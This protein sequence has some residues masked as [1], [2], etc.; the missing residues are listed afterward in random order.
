MYAIRSYY[1]VKDNICVIIPAILKKIVSEYKDIVLVVVE[2]SFD[3]IKE[4]IKDNEENK[5]IKNIRN[6]FV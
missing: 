2:S 5:S 6:N 4:F 1:D 3:I